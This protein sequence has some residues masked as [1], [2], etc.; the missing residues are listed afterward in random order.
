M[1]NFRTE[2]ETSQHNQM[3]KFGK[4]E[5]ASSHMCGKFLLDSQAGGIIWRMPLLLLLLSIKNLVSLQ[6]SMVMEVS[7]F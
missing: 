1:G 2:P 7:Y 5:F 3:G 6:S 4:L